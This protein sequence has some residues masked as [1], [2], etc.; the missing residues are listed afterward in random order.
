MLALKR[1]HDRV[2]SSSNDNPH[3][4]EPLSSERHPA[5]A[6]SE[7]AIESMETYLRTR[8]LLQPLRALLDALPTTT[9][10]TEEHRE[11]LQQELARVIE[12]SNSDSSLYVALA[13]DIHPEVATC[14]KAIKDM[15]AH[16]QKVKEDGCLLYTSPS[17]RD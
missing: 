2:V 13:A 10:T 11:A 4:Y 3:V 6:A 7:A 5:V 9:Q 1:V 15:L 14:E 17:P 8:Q 12:T 16:E